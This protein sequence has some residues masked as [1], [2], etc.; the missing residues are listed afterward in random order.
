MLSYCLTPEDKIN[1]FKELTKELS[2]RLSK[3][4]NEVQK[5]KKG[6]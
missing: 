5:F 6:L 4:D 2:D 1:V 3:A